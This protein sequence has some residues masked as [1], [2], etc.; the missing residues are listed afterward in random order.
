M[1]ALVYQN[2]GEVVIEERPMPIPAEGEVQ[3]QIKNVSICGSDIGAYRHY[4]ERFK[5]PLV[6]GHEFSGIITDIGQRVKGFD[7]G[8]RV[9]VN[10]IMY[11]GK[12]YHC[13]RGEINLCGYRRSLGTAIGGT[14]TDG[15]MREYMTMRTSNLVPI[16][17]AVSYRDGALLEPMAVCLS[18]ARCG[19]TA[20]EENT[21]VMGAGPIGL[22]NVKFLKALGI[23]NVIVTDVLDARLQKAKDFGAN[24]VFNPCHVSVTANIK[25]LTNGIGADRVIIAAGVPGAIAEA[26]TMVRNG[27]NVVLVAMIHDIIEFDPMQI[28]SRG[29]NLLGSYMFTTEMADAMKMVSEGKMSVDGIVTSSFSLEDGKQALDLITSPGNSEIKVQMTMNQ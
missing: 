7:I 2:P 22:L 5:P 25:E 3:I 20:G 17:D 4:S 23:K 13:N 16:D 14:Q 24:H 29:C 27:G 15:A 26:F 28:M 21:V 12:C 19:L 9:A 11:C 6:I 10:P 1:R 8:Q 18:S